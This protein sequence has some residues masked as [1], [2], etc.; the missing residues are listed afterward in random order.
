MSKSPLASIRSGTTPATCITTA[1][2]PW[3]DKVK[4]IADTAAAHDCACT[5]GVNCGSVD[6]DKLGKFPED[7]SIS[8]M[9]AS[10]WEHCELLDSLGF[11]R[12]L[13]SL[14]DS[15]SG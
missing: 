8:P 5:V 13:V 1:P 9:F 15:R 11:T 6:P 10:A 4:L 7:D 12:Y 2:K 3:Q 14:K